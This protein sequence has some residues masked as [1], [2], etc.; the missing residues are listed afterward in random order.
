MEAVIVDPWT[1]LVGDLH[2][3]GLVHG[4]CSDQRVHNLLTLRFYIMNSHIY[5]EFVVYCTYIYMSGD[6]VT[7]DGVWDEQLSRM[8]KLLMHSLCPL[9]LQPTYLVGLLAVG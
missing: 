4:I 3:C 9:H 8:P 5:I 2:M 7:N 1:L 6:V